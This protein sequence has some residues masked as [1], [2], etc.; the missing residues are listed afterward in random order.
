MPEYLCPTTHEPCAVLAVIQ[1]L[2]DAEHRF[3]GPNVANLRV[4]EAVADDYARNKGLEREYGQRF[5]TGQLCGM[6]AVA[7]VLGQRAR[8]HEVTQTK[9]TRGQITPRA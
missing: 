3:T 4:A 9:V 5:C 7:T 1:A 8:A 2:P 6:V